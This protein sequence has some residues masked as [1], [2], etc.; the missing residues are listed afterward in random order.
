MDGP[1][2]FKWIVIGKSGAGKT[3]IL[4]R[5]VNNEFK[6]GTQSTIGIEYFTYSMECNGQKVKLN[7]WDTAG[8]EQ[9]YT[10]TKAYYRSAVGVILVYDILER[11]TFEDLPRWLRDA[12]LEA[13]PKCEII[14]VGNKTDKEADRQVSEAEA[15]DFITAHNIGDYIE[16]SAL[17]GQNV[18][19]IFERLAARILEKLKNKEI[20]A[21][22][23]PISP[24]VTINQNEKSGCC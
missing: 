21:I 10:V 11:K 7:I 6:E 22:P 4:K 8:Q 14:L 1:L 17:N 20:K 12:R 19:D 13:D 16:V 18:T 23:A 2:Q 24:S 3:C 5:L 15:M 9:F